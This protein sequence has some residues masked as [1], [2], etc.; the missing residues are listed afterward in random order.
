[1]TSATTLVAEYYKGPERS[2]FMG[3]QAAFMSFGRVVFL[4]AGG[5]LAEL[6]WRWPFAIYLFPLLLVPLVIFSLIEPVQS[7]DSSHSGNED[8][9]AV[10]N[11]GRLL[12]LIYGIVFLGMTIA[13]S[14]LFGMATSLTY[15]R[16]RTRI[17]YLPILGLNF[18]LMGTGYLFIGLGN[19][20]LAVLTGLVR[21]WH[22]TDVSVPQCLADFRNPGG[23][24]RACRRRL[25][26]LRVS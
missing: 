4:T 1:M 17:G 6:G 14:T 16:I 9:S 2:Q 8:E 10:G 15:G 23:S 11:P 19:G 21:T 24:A 7:G 5:G 20:Y 22:G 25:N 18:G 26:H 13:V 12:P 3:W